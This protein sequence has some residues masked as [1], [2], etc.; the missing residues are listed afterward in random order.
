MVCSILVA[1]F[2]MQAILNVHAGH[3]TRGRVHQVFQPWSEY[4]F[5]MND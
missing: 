4:S 5:V 1:K 3:M 2:L